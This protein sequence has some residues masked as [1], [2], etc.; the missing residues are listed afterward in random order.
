[1]TSTV[2]VRQLTPAD[3]DAYR[4]LRLLALRAS[5]AAFGSSYEDEAILPLEAF[6]SRLDGGTGLQ[7]FGAFAS[8]EIVGM[9]GLG[10]LTGPK[11][12]HRT[13]VRS[14]FV[15]PEAR[16]QGVGRQLLV[17]VLGLADAMDG[18]RQVTLTVTAGNDSARRLYEAH[19]FAP[20]GQAPEALFVDGSYHDDVLMVRRVGA[21]DARPAVTPTA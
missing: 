12:R 2:T 9:V 16:G 15:R 13:E 1:M 5:P 17:H 19:G 8:G 18:V 14:M 20:Y 6:T 7:L 4:E 21:R 3:V 11:E 10:R